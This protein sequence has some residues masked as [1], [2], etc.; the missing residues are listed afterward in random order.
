MAQADTYATGKANLRDNVKVLLGALAGV[1]G[2]LL[3][4][5]PFSGFGALPI[6]WRF[7]AAAFGLTIAV[8]FCT[9]AMWLL[10]RALQP[11]QL[12]Y[13]VLR[14][15]YDLKSIK[16]EDMRAE[17][18]EL[19][20][21]FDNQR[22]VLLPD[23]L[24]KDTT[25]KAHSIEALEAYI[26]KLWDALPEKATEADSA[27]FNRFHGLLYTLTDWAAFTRLQRRVVEAMR[28]ALGIGFAGLAGIL[29]FAWAVNP[30][31]APEGGNGPTVIVHE[32]KSQAALPPAR[33]F[34][35]VLFFTDDDKLNKAD[36]SVVQQALDHLRA[37]ADHAVLIRAYTDTQGSERRNGALA[38]KRA[39][40]V[41]QALVGPG[42]VAPNRVFVAALGTTDL[43]MVSPAGVDQPA[44]RSA[45]MIVVPL[46]AAAGSAAAS[47]AS[48]PM[49]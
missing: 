14:D 29:L 16:D 8:G 38:G 22:T 47:A 13:V 34:G 27:E 4:G 25:L 41:A 19:K 44:N 43:P 5:T 15:S 11:D 33:K 36:W 23:G 2:V 37:N 40:A 35:P 21:V 48:S 26:D 18:A 45:W 28:N 30:S 31:K 12:S 3:A 20:K 7:A 9:R 17:V 42:G 32:Q 1:A 10:V 49:R 24:E 46:Q 6:G 39:Q